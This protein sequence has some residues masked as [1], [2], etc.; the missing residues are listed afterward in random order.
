MYA[1]VLLVGLFIFAVN[2][3]AI[4]DA[5]KELQKKVGELEASEVRSLKERLEISI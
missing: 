5:I 3:Y 4:G 1:M 2:F